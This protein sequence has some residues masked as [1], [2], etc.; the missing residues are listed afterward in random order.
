MIREEGRQRADDRYGG[1]WTYIPLSKIETLSLSE[2]DNGLLSLSIQ[3]PDHD[4]LE[5]LF[6]APAKPEVT[7]ILEQ[8]KAMTQP[9]PS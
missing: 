5:C 1:I 7:Q 4:R 9:H 8:F 3:L 2:K 6:E